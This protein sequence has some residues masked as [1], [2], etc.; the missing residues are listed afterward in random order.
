MLVAT[1]NQLCQEV[2]VVPLLWV[3]PLVVY[4]GTFI[5]TFSGQG[6]YRRGPWTIL[7]ALL[8]L[9][10]CAL[11]YAGPRTPFWLQ[12]AGYT[13]TL[14]AVGMCCHGELA[15]AQPPAR[16]STL[17]YLCLAAGGAIGGVLVTLVAPLVFQGY[18]E[19]HLG[20]LAACV[21]VAIAAHRHGGWDFRRQ[22]ALRQA[23]GVG[24][25]TLVVVLAGEMYYGQLNAT[26]AVRNFYGVLRI[27]EGSDAVGPYRRMV[28][29]RIDHGRQYLGDEQRRWPTLYFGRGSGIDLAMRLHRAA[30]A[31]ILSAAKNLARCHPR[32]L[33]P[34][35]VRTTLGATTTRFMSPSSAWARARSPPTPRGATSSAIMKSIP[36]SWTCAGGTSPSSKTPRASGRRSRSC[37]ATRGL[38]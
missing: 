26:H 29:G 15:R 19:Y 34:L 23:V 24:L 11:L 13:L 5:V 1:T 16:H 22:P 10:T 14:L 27:V 38:A 2:A 18:W 7:L 12:I 32:P 8:M 9:P 6:G 31:V 4:L 20:L 35:R 33:A 25:V 21:L 30:P 17:Y 28:H 3:L 37:W 36:P